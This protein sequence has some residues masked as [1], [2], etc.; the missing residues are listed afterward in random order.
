MASRWLAVDKYLFF[1]VSALMGLGLIMVY[2]ASFA[3]S[4][5]LYGN[6]VYL[7]T[8][9][10]AAMALGLLLLLA[11]MLI[12]YRQYQRPAVVATAVIGIL[13]ALAFVL[14]MPASRGSHRWISLGFFNIQ[15][16]EFAKL[17][18]ILFLASFLSRKDDR[19]NEFRRG[20][21]P[22]L[23]VVG[24]ILL[25]VAVEPDLGTACMIAAIAGTMLWVGGLSLKYV[26][27]LA[28]IGGVAATAQVLRSGYQ[29]RRIIAYLDPWTHELD[30][31]YQ[32]VQSLA[33]VGA[34][35]VTG[36]GFAAGQQ[37]FG[38]LPD[39]YTDFIYAVLGEEFGLVGTVAVVL[40]FMVILWRGLRA[41][42]RAP[43]KFG[44]YMGVGLT[45]FLVLQALINMSIVVNLL[46]TTGIP[47]PMI[48]YGGSSMLASCIAVGLLLNLSQHAHT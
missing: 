8:R 28:I 3:I 5:R 45:C 37:K 17:A 34:G 39:P 9:Q 36:S 12:D 27:N 15:P 41:A 11:C 24:S 7:L 18:V 35:G 38:F 48:S 21:L 2:S 6:D 47:L 32:T 23:L 46:P 1:A 10:G 19:L 44:F 43:D 14:L 33:A 42:L 29:S 26:A 16:S 20:L 22:I 40:A 25:L 30:A 13:A 4:Q 31:G